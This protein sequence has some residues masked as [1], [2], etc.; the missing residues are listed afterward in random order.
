MQFE[1]VQTLRSTGEAGIKSLVIAT[2]VTG[3]M[4]ILEDAT[5]LK[6]TQGKIRIK[7][8]SYDDEMRRWLKKAQAD[9][10]AQ[11]GSIPQQTYLQEWGKWPLKG[12]EPSINEVTVGRH[13]QLCIE[14]ATS[15]QIWT[16]DL[17][18]VTQITV[19]E[20]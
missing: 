20:T 14:S 3:R 19:T 9:S 15:V 1:I 10:I 11:L 13:L 12:P 18:K 2:F 6:Y 4:V 17:P 8:E 16:Y 5:D 7:P